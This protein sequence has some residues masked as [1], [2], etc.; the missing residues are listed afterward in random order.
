[1]RY[2][3][4]TRA[5]GSK[6]HI[7]WRILLPRL[8]GLCVALC[9][10]LLI[11]PRT[12]TAL[13]DGGAPN[14]AYVAGGAQGLSV[15]DIGQQKVTQ[16]IALGGDPA[17]IYLTLDGRYIY[18][19]QPGLNKV[20]LLAALT[21]ATVCSI[22]VPGQPSLL[23]FDAGVNTLYVAGNGASGI[24][25]LNG[26]SCT[27]QKTIATSSPVYGMGTAEVGSGT[28]GGTGNQLWFTTT[29]ALNVYQ[30]GKIQSIA[31]VGGPQYITIP[32]G[33]TVYVT[34]H[35]GTVVAVNLQTLKATAPLL[36]GG[37]FGPMDF[38]AFTSEVYVPDKKHNQLVVLTPLAYGSDTVP[39]EPNHVIPLGV[40]P[41]SVAIT[42]DGNLGFV[43]L[44]GGN[45]AML[46]IPGKTL[47]STIAVGGN[48]R[49]II[50]GLY[51]PTTPDK[52]QTTTANGTPIP[53]TLLYIMA[54]VA[55][56]LLLVI[57]FLLIL[58]RRRKT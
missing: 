9:G 36:T 3:S 49:F 35:Q 55:L 17:M 46:D 22:T 23:A 28:N 16:N 38:D 58:A 12:P 48:P 32:A 30:D 6:G 50:T 2:T 56:L 18:V 7:L 53:A 24:T 5:Q 47:I 10:M 14:L 33:A 25:A 52:Q 37:D 51:P 57:A 40:A 4:F 42:S 54:V 39:P 26:N 34:T 8:L 13:A 19:A 11:A 43:A 31:I 20:T 15:V 44:A 21:G 1:M 45:V 29:S 41:Q 27:L